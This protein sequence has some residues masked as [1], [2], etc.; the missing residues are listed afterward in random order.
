MSQNKHNQIY[1]VCPHCNNGK[2]QYMYEHFPYSDEHLWC[3][4]CNSTFLLNYKQMWME[5]VNDI[6]SEVCNFVEYKLERREMKLR[7]DI[8]NEIFDAIQNILE[9]YSTGDYK[10]HI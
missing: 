5:D 10:K 4:S 2:L 8:S 7:D 1:D 3:E 6:A 9:K